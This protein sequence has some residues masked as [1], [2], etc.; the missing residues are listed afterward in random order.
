M[1]RQ[2]INK[3]PDSKS[4]VSWLSVDADSW[5]WALGVKQGPQSPSAAPLPAPPTSPESEHESDGGNFPSQGASGIV[6]ASDA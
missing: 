3:P 6:Q 4:T 1:T 5:S 2:I